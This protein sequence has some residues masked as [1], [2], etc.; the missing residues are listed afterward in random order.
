MGCGKKI[1]T[2]SVR[3]WKGFMLRAGKRHGVREE[4]FGI[5][6]DFD[7]MQGASDG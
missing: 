4:I 5:S 1:L 7:Q 6:K 2:G 3:L